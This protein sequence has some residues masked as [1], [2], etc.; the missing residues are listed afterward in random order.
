MTLAQLAQHTRDLMPGAKVILEK[1]HVH[2]QWG[3]T[4]PAAP[5]AAASKAQEVFR[6]V[7]TPPSADYA[8][9]RAGEGDPLF[10]PGTTVETDAKTGNTRVLQAPP[11]ADAA[12]GGAPKL[13]ASDNAF[14]AKL[15]NQFGE[16]QTMSSNMDQFV[17][18]NRNVATGGKMALPGMGTVLS[19]VNP[20]IA[21]MQ[22]IT[23]K[24]TPAMR[25]GLPG[26]ASDRDVAMFRGA[27][28]GLDKPLEANQN[29]RDAAK[30]FA[31][32]SGDYLAF[33]ETYAAKK[34]TL[35]GSTEIW[36]NYVDTHP[37]FGG[38]RKDGSPIVNK[39]TPWRAVISLGGESAPSGFWTRSGL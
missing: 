23:N 19:A 4:A 5:A 27:T 30:A 2:V 8:V 9:R 11:K 26:A 13:N 22:S 37:L 33:L 15:R 25:N 14:L 36:K 24:L 29:I 16:L 21:T 1:D 31:G 6:G 12:T 10:S 7:A 34:G 28:V 18:L 39:N 20:Q 3:G 38:I 17:Q 35:L 32:R